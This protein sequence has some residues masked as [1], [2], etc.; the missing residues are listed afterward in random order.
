MPKHQAM[1]AN[2]ES[3]GETPYPPKTDLRNSEIWEITFTLLSLESR[4]MTFHFPL[5]RTVVRLSEIN[6]KQAQE[7][8]VILIYNC[9]GVIQGKAM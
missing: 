8:Q 1:K 6:W 2:T 9:S 7:V 3:G 4:W 5:G